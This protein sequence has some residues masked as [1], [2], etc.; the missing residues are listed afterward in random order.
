MAIAVLSLVGFFVAVY[1]FAHSMGWTG[2][3]VCGVGD[4]AT[5][6]A[7]RYAWVGPFPV[8]GVG[9]GGYVAL[10]V[11]A[12]AGLQPDRAASPWIAR[13]L[14][15][16]AAFGVAFSGYLTYL[17]AAVINAWCQWCVISAI[18]MTLIFLASLPEWRRIGSAG[19]GGGGAERTAE[20]V[21]DRAAEGIGT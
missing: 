13:L 19:A 16:G 10:F 20:P 3:I 9:L 21:S 7:S 4:C 2:P 11:L 12:M 5:V 14:A 8:S 15:L 18:L 1:L 17:E 6:Q